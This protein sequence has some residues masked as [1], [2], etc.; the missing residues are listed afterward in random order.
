MESEGSVR[1]R[2][3]QRVRSGSEGVIGSSQGLRESD[4][5]VRV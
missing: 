4:G 2:G 3:S 1:V 5:P